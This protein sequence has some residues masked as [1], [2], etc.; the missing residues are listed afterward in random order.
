M[1]YVEYGVE[2]INIFSL[3]SIQYAPGSIGG[4][5]SRSSISTLVGERGQESDFLLDEK[6]ANFFYFPSFYPFL[7]L[8]ISMTVKMYQD[9]L[10]DYL[11]T[12]IIKEPAIDP[13]QCG[14]W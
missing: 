14:S 3:D 10:S 8:S 12:W 1:L 9:T 4:T 11:N 5:F 2:L 6:T 7:Q 13:N